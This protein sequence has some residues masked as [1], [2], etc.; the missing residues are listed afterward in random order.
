[1]KIIFPLKLDTIDI[2][3]TVKLETRAKSPYTT[4]YI[5]SQLKTKGIFIIT[6][7]QQNNKQS[8]LFCV[9]SY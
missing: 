7:T 3:C 8:N 4:L 1:M 5:K 2:I 9:L 6:R